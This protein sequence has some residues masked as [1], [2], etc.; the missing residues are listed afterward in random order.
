[1][2]DKQIITALG[3]GPELDEF[4]VKLDQLLVRDD[5]PAPAPWLDMVVGIKAVGHGIC[6]YTSRYDGSRMPGADGD[7]RPLWLG[8][9]GNLHPGRDA[10][11]AM[12]GWFLRYGRGMPQT[13]FRLDP[14]QPVPERPP[15]PFFTPLSAV[16]LGTWFFGSIELAPERPCNEPYP[17]RSELADTAG[18]KFVWAEDLATG[19]EYLCMLVRSGPLARTCDAAVACSFYYPYRFDFEDYYEKSWTGQMAGTWIARP[20]PRQKPPAVLIGGL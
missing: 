6:A 1:M 13:G 18:G 19:R 12:R 11:A 5:D 7:G 20:R 10:M 17:G 16:A 15:V 4:P 14:D 9:A 8:A 3:C 2:T